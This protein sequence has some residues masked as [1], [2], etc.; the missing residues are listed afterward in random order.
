MVRDVLDMCEQ[1]ENSKDATGEAGG[2]AGN[3]VR[4]EDLRD[5]GAPEVGRDDG[6]TAW[7]STEGDRTFG[8]GREHVLSV[9]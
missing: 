5:D 8:F 4:S 1:T 3:N 7:E 9:W 2:G 6:D